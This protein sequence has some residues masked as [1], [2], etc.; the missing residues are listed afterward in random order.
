MSISLKRVLKISRPR[1]W[2]Y[3]LG[4][5]FVGVV[6]GGFFGVSIVNLV[7]WGVYFLISA[8][9]LIYGIND[10]YDYD[11]DKLNPKKQNYEDLLELSDHKRLYFWIFLT[12]IPFIFFV[13]NLPLSVILS[14]FLFIFFATFYSAKP[15][16]AKARPF[17]DSFFSAGH[18]VATGVFGYFLTNPEHAFPLWGILAGMSWAISM[19][20]YSAVPDIE[21]DSNGGLATIATYL[22]K[23]KTILLCTLLY[24]ISAIIGSLLVG[25]WISIL[26][27][28][29][30]VIMYK[31]YFAD[32]IFLFKLYKYFPILNAF[33]GMIIFWSLL[34]KIIF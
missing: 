16:R 32:E 21:S 3:E 23:N 14:L 5:F 8:N 13:F 1:F 22:G 26:L 10:I 27:I 34:L 25:W 17:F 31:S 9:I 6:A 18:Y 20:A 11:T 7:V 15:I 29:Y 19:H 2:L 33:S 30:L 12:N 4:T 24:T 28:P